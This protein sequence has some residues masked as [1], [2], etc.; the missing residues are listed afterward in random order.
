MLLGNDV[1]AWALLVLSI[2][3]TL[4]HNN[5]LFLIINVFFVKNLLSNTLSKNGK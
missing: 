1:G 5:P 3:L 4:A 2:V